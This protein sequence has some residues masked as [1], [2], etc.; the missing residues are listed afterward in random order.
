MVRISLIITVFAALSMVC[1][2]QTLASFEIDL[3][4]ATNGIDVPVTM[5]ITKFKI[6]PYAVFSLIEVKDNKKTVV[7]YQLNTVDKT[8]S[9]MIRQ[10][11][12]ETKKHF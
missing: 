3:S 10:S 5:G 6:D 9:W 4:K 11:G 7:P 1:K 8:I 12:P 2:A